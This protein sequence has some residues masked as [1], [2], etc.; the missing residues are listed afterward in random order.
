MTGTKGLRSQEG[1]KAEVCSIHLKVRGL[2]M[3]DA[4]LIL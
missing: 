4:R 2:R 1:N 3:Q